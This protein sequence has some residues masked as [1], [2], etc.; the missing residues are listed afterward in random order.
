MVC[1][2]SLP[3]APAGA[4]RPKEAQLLRQ[5]EC[6]PPLHPH[7]GVL[8]AGTTVRA[9][10]NVKGVQEAAE[11]EPELWRA[12]GEFYYWWVVHCSWRPCSP[13]VTIILRFLLEVFRN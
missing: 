12:S 2:P 10:W 7:W 3:P 13:A 11:T 6:R 1:G 4:Q 5:C 8:I 9:A